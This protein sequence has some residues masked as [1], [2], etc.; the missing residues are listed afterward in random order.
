VLRLDGDAR[1]WWKPHHG[2]E[3]EHAYA[4]GTAGA[5]GGACTALQAHVLAHLR[6]GAPLENAARDYL[7]N[8]HVQ[9]AIYHSHAAGRRVPMAEFDPLTTP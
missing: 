7:V 4:S 8:L 3:A 2:V 5:F 9:A 1:L 6:H